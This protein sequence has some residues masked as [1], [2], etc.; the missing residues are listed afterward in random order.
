[1]EAACLVQEQDA[2]NQERGELQKAHDASLQ[3]K[4]DIILFI[5]F[6]FVPVQSSMRPQT[7][8]SVGSG[9]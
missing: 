4:N 9:L 7:W 2:D 5:C 3:E 8:P 6:S 1:M